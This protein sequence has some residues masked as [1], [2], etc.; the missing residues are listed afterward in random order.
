VEAHKKRKSA[1]GSRLNQVDGG[2]ATSGEKVDSTTALVG[3][4]YS[5]HW[6][7]SAKT[8]NKGGRILTTDVAE[9]SSLE[10]WGSMRSGKE[11]TGQGG[12]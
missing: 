6:G 12:V 2:R 11:F 8:R 1:Y 5:T 4:M 10:A 7:D 3:G 9:L